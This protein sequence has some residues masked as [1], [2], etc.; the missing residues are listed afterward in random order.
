MRIMRRKRRIVQ[1]KVDEKRLTSACLHLLSH[2]D[3][4]GG[5]IPALGVRRVYRQNL[6]RALDVRGYD[7]G[8]LRAYPVSPRQT[9]SAAAKWTSAR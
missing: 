1:H 7:I 2:F 8:Q 4:K 9:R 5:L 3:F 6:V